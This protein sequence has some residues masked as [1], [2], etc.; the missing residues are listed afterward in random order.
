MNATENHAKNQAVCQL[1]GIRTM[2]AAIQCDYDRLE[3]LRDERDGYEFDP[4]A[5]AAPDGPSYANNREAWAGENPEAAEELTELE[6]AAGDCE[7]AEEA[8]QRIHEDPLSCQVRS[9]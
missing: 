7:D 9:D 1:A 3:E 6:E 4:D 8:Q 2:L 5:N